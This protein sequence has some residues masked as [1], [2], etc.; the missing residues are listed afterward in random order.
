VYICVRLQ[1]D[2]LVNSE[3]PEETAERLSDGPSISLE[4]AMQ[5]YDLTDAG[6]FLLAL[7]IV[8]AAWEHYDSVWMRRRWTTETIRFLPQLPEF[9]KSTVEYRPLHPYVVI[10]YEDADP[11]DR[12][13]QAVEGVVHKALRCFAL[14]VI[15]VTIFGKPRVRSRYVCLTSP[16]QFNN[17]LSSYRDFLSNDKWLNMDN[18]SGELSDEITQV[19]KA[20]FDPFLFRGLNQNAEY[21]RSILHDHVLEPLERLVRGSGLA[22]A[23][24]VW[25]GRRCVMKDLAPETTS[26][27]TDR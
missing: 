8:R 23:P 15:L 24:A 13:E 22:E 1:Q 19:V 10:S 12:T 11:A 7:R 4:F 17:E 20:C 21:R 14:G 5:E 25:R 6:K 27:T 9:E 26:L 18:D 2:S 3:I 16:E